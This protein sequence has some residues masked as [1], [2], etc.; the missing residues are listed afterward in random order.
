MY[1]DLLGTTL[2]GALQMQE[3]ISIITH[4]DDVEGTMHTPGLH[5][6]ALEDRDSVMVSPRPRAKPSTN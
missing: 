4:A 1:P 6:K 2:T 5:L 3:E